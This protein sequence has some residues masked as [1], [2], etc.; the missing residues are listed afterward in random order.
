LRRFAREVVHS[1]DCTWLCRAQSTRDGVHC[2]GLSIAFLRTNMDACCQFTPRVHR[3]SLNGGVWKIILC[4]SKCVDAWQN[5]LRI[6]A[7]RL[8]LTT[9]RVESDLA[10]QRALKCS[11]CAY[12][13]SREHTG[14]RCDCTAWRT[15]IHVSECVCDTRMLSRQSCESAS[16]ENQIGTGDE[17]INASETCRV[18]KFI[19][20]L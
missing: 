11:E 6:E 14:F 5:S 18:L 9:A 7:N 1:G 16:R 17:V 15:W 2:H 3:V 20:T 4:V 13:S 8:S 12:A 19:C 10:S